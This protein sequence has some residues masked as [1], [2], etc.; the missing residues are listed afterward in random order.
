[1][2][3]VLG[4][5]RRARRSAAATEPSVESTPPP[6]QFSDSTP[7]AGDDAA[8]QMVG[9]T[10]L[11]PRLMPVPAYAT[12]PVNSRDPSRQSRN[13]RYHPPWV[14]RAPHVTQVHEATRLAHRQIAQNPPI[15]DGGH[16]GV[17]AHAQRGCHHDGG[18]LCMTNGC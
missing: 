4:G 12:R 14:R 8:G 7:V 11:Y 5:N 10:V 3:L 6:A 15:G 1:M 18:T 2:P 13:S 17:D 9:G 16:G